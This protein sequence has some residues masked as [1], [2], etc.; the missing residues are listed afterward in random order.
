MAMK[1]ADYQKFKALC[2]QM[3]A[4]PTELASLLAGSSPIG[5]QLFRGRRR[6]VDEDARLSDVAWSDFISTNKKRLAKAISDWEDWDR[7]PDRKGCFRFFGRGNVADL[8]KIKAV[9]AKAD[10]ILGQYGEFLPVLKGD[11][12]VPDEFAWKLPQDVEWVYRNSAADADHYYLLETICNERGSDYRHEDVLLEDAGLE[13][14]DEEDGPFGPPSRWERVGLEMLSVH[15]LRAA[16][17]TTIDEWVPYGLEDVPVELEKP[18]EKITEPAYLFA[19]DPKIGK[20]HVRF[21]WGDKP[22]D[23]EE[24][25]LPDQEA[26]KTK[27]KQGVPNARYVAYI[28]ER[29]NQDIPCVSLFPPPRPIPDGSVVG[30]SE[31]ES[32]P[33]DEQPK[34]RQQDSLDYE[35]REQHYRMFRWL[36]AEIEKAT[37]KGDKQAVKKLRADLKREKR[38]FNRKYD[39]FGNPRDREKERETKNA[40]DRVRNAIDRFR[41]M[42]EPSGTHPLPH[43]LDHLKK[44][45]VRGDSCIYLPD[46]KTSRPVKWQVVPPPGAW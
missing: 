37:Q 39:K 29:P 6:R 20:W 16:F 26:G 9:L 46:S 30:E 4:L 8:D 44:I 3:R 25:Y 12:L 23:V 17:T 38:D 33:R 35:D 24:G 40:R 22:D 32:Q 31:I 11:R 41:E 13:V 18:T 15:D 2:E 36:A 21:R 43:L 5:V 1:Q 27:I 10:E 34:R 28:L 45:K 7:L 19:F 14:V 42:L